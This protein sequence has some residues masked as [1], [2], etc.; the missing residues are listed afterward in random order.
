MSK[1][2]LSVGLA[3]K[4]EKAFGRNDWTLSEIDKLCEGNTLARHRRVMLG[5]AAIQDLP[6]AEPVVK[7]KDEP[8]II[9]LGE[10]E[11]DYDQSI[12]DKLK[13]I[14]DAKCIGWRI[15]LATDEKFPDRRTGKRSFK[16][17]A[18]NFGRQMPDEGKGSIGEWCASNKKIRATPK[19][20]IDIAKVSPRPKLDNVMPLAVTGQFF[21]GAHD[22]RYALYFN[23]DGDKRYLSDVWLN[24]DEQWIDFWWFLV[25][26]ELPSK[27]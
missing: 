4:L 17:S 25:L 10:F 13:G 7:P 15:D 2:E 24:P 16:A 9:E 20:G 21:V 22:D 18:V 26:E 6:P 19:E 8:T 27:A 11:F 23:L 1:L 12:A 5:T 3:V 14:T